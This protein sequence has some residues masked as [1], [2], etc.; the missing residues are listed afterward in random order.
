MKIA[1]NIQSKWG[2]HLGFKLNLCFFCFRWLSDAHK[3]SPALNIALN[4]VRSIDGEGTCHLL[5]GAFYCLV[6]I[7]L[8]R[9]M[10]WFQ[11]S[12]DFMQN[13]PT[14]SKFWIATLF[15]AAKGLNHV[16]L[17]SMGSLCFHSASSNASEDVSIKFALRS[18]SSKIQKLQDPTLVQ[19]GQFNGLCEPCHQSPHQNSVVH[20][21]AFQ[22]QDK[23]MRVDPVSSST[24]LSLAF[25]DV[26]FI[27]KQSHVPT[28][29]PWQQIMLPAALL[30]T[31]T[32]LNAPAPLPHPD[33]SYDIAPALAV[34]MPQPEPHLPRLESP[35]SDATSGS[36]WVTKASNNEQEHEGTEKEQCLVQP[37]QRRNIK[38]D[39]CL[40][41]KLPL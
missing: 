41:R 33:S 18:Y 2:T 11:K 6:W 5:Y 36:S 27:T 19:M 38:K 13:S 17:H 35:I 12:K 20:C 37:S 4:L 21:K 29:E 23:V 31:I 16:A 1:C 34:P 14:V 28:T 10:Q 3:G 15:A 39:T 32:L 24:S 9:M 22:I 25:F 7:S 30:T 40:L 26:T 8:T